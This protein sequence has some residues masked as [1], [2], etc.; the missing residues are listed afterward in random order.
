VWIKKKPSTTSFK[1]YAL[2]FQA[3]S[4]WG[5]TR[6]AEGGAIGSGLTM[7]RLGLE[8]ARWGNGVALRVPWRGLAGQGTQ[9]VSASGAA[10]MAIGRDQMEMQLLLLNLG[11]F[12]KMPHL[13]WHLPQRAHLLWHA[14][15][16]LFYFAHLL[17]CPTYNLSMQ[18]VSPSN[19]KPTV[20]A[21]PLHSPL[22]WLNSFS[23]RH[24]CKSAQN[25]T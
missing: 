17:K 14:W 6:D 20:T 3:V 12:D 25:W 15:D 21:L 2:P 19:L 4:V 5:A 10:A 11:L 16:A 9:S 23:F 22:S 8:V 18:Q 7:G 13:L 24:D 1:K